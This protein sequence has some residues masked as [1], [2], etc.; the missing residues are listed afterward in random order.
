M[1]SRE[2]MT[3]IILGILNLF[4]IVG[5][6]MLLVFGAVGNNHSSGRKGKK[7]ELEAQ[8]NEKAEQ[9]ETSYTITSSGE[10]EKLKKEELEEGVS[11]E[12]EDIDVEE[13]VL[14]IRGIFNSVQKNL[15][16]YSSSSISMGKSYASEDGAY[17]KITINKGENGIDYARDYYYE[18]NKLIFAFCYKGKW[19]Q[20][21]YFHNE[22][23]F[24][25]INEDKTIYDQKTEDKEWQ[26]WE[27]SILKEARLVINE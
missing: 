1:S 7:V 15:D 27:T 12:K 10:V 24:R 23:M 4:A 3:A 20:R 13:E 25:W 19:E 11:T 22:V 6:I 16:S 14:R 18:D 9:G 17:Q 2:K 5:C 26:E 8:F 21:F